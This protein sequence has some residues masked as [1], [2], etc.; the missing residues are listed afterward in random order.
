MFHAAT[1]E[2]ETGETILAGVQETHDMVMVELMMGGNTWEYHH[3]TIEKPYQITIKYM[4]NWWFI[5]G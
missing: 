5:H 3:L 4:A 1:E 2:I